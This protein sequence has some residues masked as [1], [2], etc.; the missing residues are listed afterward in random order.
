MK[1]DN[2]TEPYSH[3][4]ERLTLAMRFVSHIRAMKRPC[5]SV[6]IRLS[7]CS[8]VQPIY[9]RFPI[10]FS[11]CFSIATIGYSPTCRSSLQPVREGIPP[12]FS[13]IAGVG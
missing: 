12:S 13:R 9:T 10:I 8:T 2:A 7:L 4:M 11:R 5:R 1:T 3:Q 6:Y